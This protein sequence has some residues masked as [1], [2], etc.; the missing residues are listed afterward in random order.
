MK[1]SAKDYHY[2]IEKG[3]PTYMD[4]WRIID[5]MHKIIE[6]YHAGTYVKVP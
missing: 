3:K 5:K 4:C 2:P 6:V 1:G